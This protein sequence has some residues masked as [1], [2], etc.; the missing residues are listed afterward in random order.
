MSLLLASS[1]ITQVIQSWINEFSQYEP[2]LYFDWDTFINLLEKEPLALTAVLIA[3]FNI[4]FTIMF[5]LSDSWKESRKE[6]LQRAVLHIE[7]YP[8]KATDNTPSALQVVLT[9]V[10]RE[11]LVIRDVG[12]QQRPLAL[13]L[14]HNLSPIRIPTYKPFDRSQVY[15]DLPEVR[16]PVV[17]HPKEFFEF[18]IQGES[19]KKLKKAHQRFTVRDSLGNLWLYRGASISRFIKKTHSPTPSTKKQAYQAVDVSPA[20]VA[21]ADSSP[22]A[23]SDIQL[24]DTFSDTAIE[25]QNHEVIQTK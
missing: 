3:F 13:R 23:D 7:A 21:I 16:W 2:I 4:I 10:G 11:P 12:Y 5:K 9:N 6:S 15:D 19:L 22:L 20:L 25:H 1:S 14:L 17:I 8:I 24:Q 18:Q